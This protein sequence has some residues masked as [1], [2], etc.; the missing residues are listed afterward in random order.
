[1]ENLNKME[2][3]RALIQSTT[4]LFIGV[5]NSKGYWIEYC[6]ISF[7]VNEAIRKEI[8]KEIRKS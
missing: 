5:K 8:F 6:K 2:I 7:D 4:H 3:K 1:M